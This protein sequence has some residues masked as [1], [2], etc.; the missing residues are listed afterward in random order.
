M[1]N[2]FSHM[3]GDYLMVVDGLLGPGDI[4]TVFFALSI[5]VGRDTFSW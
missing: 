5:M 4:E 3:A 1:L 2:Q